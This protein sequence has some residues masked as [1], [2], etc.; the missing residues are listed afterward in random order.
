MTRGLSAAARTCLGKNAGTRTDFGSCRMGNCTFWKLPF[1]KILLGKCHL[2]K[3]P[4]EVA[5]WEN[6][7]GKLPLGKILLGS[8][9]LGKYSW[10]VSTWENT[11][12]K[13]PLGKITLGVYL[14]YNIQVDGGGR[15]KSSGGKSSSIK[16]RIQMRKLIKEANKHE[17]P[18]G[19]LSDQGHRVLEIRNWITPPPPSPRSFLVYVPRWG[20]FIW[21]RFAC[22]CTDFTACSICLKVGLVL[23]MNRN[24]QCPTPSREFLKSL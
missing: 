21:S 4:W 2:G 11:L 6:T 16:S 18:S 3:Y 7:L 24:W 5:T 20:W 13:L 22:M 19:T 9:H 14:T 8:C 10:E 12:G 17:I 1:W 23:E 15:R